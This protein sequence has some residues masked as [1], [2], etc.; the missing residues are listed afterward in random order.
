MVP[1]LF[2]K[3]FINRSN[4]STPIRSTSRSV[5]A[6]SSRGRA[7]APANGSRA[8]PKEPP[9]NGFQR[10]REHLKIL[11]PPYGG[12]KRVLSGQVTAM[13]GQ[14]HRYSIRS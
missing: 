14:S 10:E 5:T 13:R 8:S 11:S 2:P 3:T 1:P 12:H 6:R 9:V 7:T 4:P